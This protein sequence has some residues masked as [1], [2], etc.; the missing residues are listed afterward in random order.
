MLF[1]PKTEYPTLESILKYYK[2][3]YKIKECK[4]FFLL[5]HT[6]MDYKEFKDNFMLDFTK[7]YI[8]TTIKSSIL[9]S[10]YRRYLQ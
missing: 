9:K 3:S 8:D 2:S 5:F 4:T 1:I 7:I 10:Y 6:S